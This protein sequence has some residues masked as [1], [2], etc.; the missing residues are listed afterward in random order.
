METH[1]V[2]GERICAPL[3]SFSLVLPI[4]RHHHEK[5]DGSG[6]PDGLKGNQIS[7]LV[8]V[9]TT[10]DI[11]DALVTD[12]SY[13]KALSRDSAFALIWKEVEQ[14]WWDGALVEE[15]QQLLGDDPGDRYT[16]PKLRAFD[17][18]K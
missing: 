14:G 16:A 1:T 8:R 3:K 5:L 18:T 7:P 13:R 12:R 11:Y 15:L 17:E 6:Y 2:I 9:L 10:V 4:I